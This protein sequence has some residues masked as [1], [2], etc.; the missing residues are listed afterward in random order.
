MTDTETRHD[1]SLDKPRRLGPYT[2]AT[3]QLLRE[4][5]FVVDWRFNAN[6]S[7]RFRVSGCPK[8]LDIK[9]VKRELTAHDMSERYRS[10]L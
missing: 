10:Y 7:P 9:H 5:G 2:R 6:G 3:V 1:P 4:K 8:G